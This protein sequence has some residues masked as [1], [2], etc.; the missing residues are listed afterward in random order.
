MTNRFTALRARLG[1]GLIFAA[2]AVGTSHVVQSTRAGAGFGLTLAVLILAI[3]ALKYPLFRFAADYAAITGENLVR[4]YGRQGR[5]LVLLMFATSAIEAIAATAGISLVSASIL[6][7]LLNVDVGDVIAAT[8]LLATT[9]VVVSLGRYRLLESLTGLL[10]VV[11]SVLT[12]VVT[13]ASLPA[14]ASVDQSFGVFPLTTQNFSFAIAVSGWMPIGNTAAI[15]LAAWILAR[16][17]QTPTTL[18]ASRFDFNTGYVTSVILAI[19][20]LL[21]GAAVL[22]SGNTPMPEASA[23]FVTTFVGL[24]T[25]AIGDWSTLLVSVAALAVMY[26]TMLAIVDGFPRLLGEFAVELGWVRG[27]GDHEQT[28]E[29]CF[30]PAMVA[31]VAS[32]SA[33]L[34]FF[35]KGFASFIDLVT[36]TGFLAA[37]VVALANQLVIR[38]T[39]VPEHLQPSSFLIRWNQ[40]AVGLLALATSGFLYLR[41]S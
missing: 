41:F 29:R 26:S 24:Y 12:I 31:V 19:C 20:F 37:P 22:Y 15:M 3:C 23:A 32:A 11:F 38:G 40:I 25:R 10:V 4:G 34:F 6:K 17:R 14:L 5:V 27:S 39:N 9:A 16:K 1:P 18:E 35:L 21:I 13:I 2:A 8:G 28:A 7:W 30:L 36:I 33:V